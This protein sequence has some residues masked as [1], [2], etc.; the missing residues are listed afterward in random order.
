MI[1]KLT[2]S[3]LR[4]LFDNSIELTEDS[5]RREDWEYLQNKHVHGLLQV[6]VAPD[7]AADPWHRIG[8]A[9]PPE[10]KWLLLQATPYHGLPKGYK[11]VATAKYIDNILV[12]FETTFGLPIPADAIWGWMEIPETEKYEEYLKENEKAH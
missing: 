12:C 7:I 6:T 4:E 5:G 3:D 1:Y 2:S 8:H 10:N 9:I 11:I